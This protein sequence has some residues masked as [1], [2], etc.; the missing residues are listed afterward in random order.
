MVGGLLGDSPE[1]AFSAN[2]KVLQNEPVA[3][4]VLRV[5]EE[6]G[7]YCQ[8][9]DQVAS[10]HG[11]RRR[12]NGGLLLVLRHVQRRSVAHA[13]RRIIVRLTILRREHHG[14][15]LAV[16][17][18]HCALLR[19]RVGSRGSGADADS[20]GRRRSADNI[21]LARGIPVPEIDLQDEEVALDS[22]GINLLAGVFVG[23][24]QTDAG[25][26]GDRSPVFVAETAHAGSL[27]LLLDSQFVAVFAFDAAEGHCFGLGLDLGG[28]AL[29]LG[30]AVHLWVLGHH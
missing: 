15:W 12:R 8:T 30:C 16:M 7:V 24:Y 1:P 29:L 27:G 21:D 18:E 13:L 14:H 10:V 22:V 19:W 23:D 9:S 28:D 25:R 5:V 6:R 3:R 11:I 17:V 26:R 2:R 20:R 4:L